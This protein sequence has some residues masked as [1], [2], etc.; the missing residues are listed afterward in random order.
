[1]ENIN[2]NIVLHDDVKLKKAIFK[3]L[4]APLKTD[5]IYIYEKDNKVIFDYPID[6]NANI[7]YDIVM[8]LNNAIDDCNEKRAHYAE[9]KERRDE[10]N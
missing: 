2:T 5:T 4:K 1:M 10:E 9:E 8:R 7:C 3:Y 6:L